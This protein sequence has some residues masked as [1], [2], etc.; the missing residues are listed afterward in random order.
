M[1][2][3]EI[4]IPEK[5]KKYFTSVNFDMTVRDLAQ[6]IGDLFKLKSPA[7]LFLGM[8]KNIKD[9]LT[10]RDIGVKNGTGVL[11]TDGRF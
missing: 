6:S 9:E 10:L 8:A 4:I 3:I 11:V 1:V 5:N 7:V 2:L